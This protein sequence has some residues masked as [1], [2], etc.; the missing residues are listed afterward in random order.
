MGLWNKIYVNHGLAKHH[1]SYSLAAGLSKTVVYVIGVVLMYS[2]KS[3]LL[4]LFKTVCDFEMN[5]SNK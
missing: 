3:V 2:N 5:S 4:R 1:S